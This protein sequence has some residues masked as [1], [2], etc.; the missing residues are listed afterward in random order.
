MTSRRRDHTAIRWLLTEF[1]LGRATDR[2][3]LASYGLQ[4][5]GRFW[6]SRLLARYPD[7][8]RPLGTWQMPLPGLLVAETERWAGAL[9]P[10]P[11]HAVTVMVDVPIATKPGED[12]AQCGTVLY[13]CK[14][15]LASDINHLV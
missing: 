15:G 6:A 14:P 13:I 3:A 12:T 7:L 2:A 9:D 10:P 8:R 1:E 5:G 11:P 4:P